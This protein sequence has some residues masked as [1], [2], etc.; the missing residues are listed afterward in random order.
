M[1]KREVAESSC[2]G[3]A[4]RRTR[5][6]FLRSKSAKNVRGKT[7]VAEVISLLENSDEEGCVNVKN[8]GPQPGVNVENAD[9]KPG[10]NGENTNPKP[11]QSLIWFICKIE[12]R[13]S[14]IEPI[15]DGLE[16]FMEE[17]SQSANEEF[18]ALRKS[19][20]NL[21]QHIDSSPSSAAPDN[22]D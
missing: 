19:I 5:P 1:S 8:A 10:V 22:S 7:E 4:P 13:V 18:S 16:K 2:A 21:N 3:S 6:Y 12:E 15:L 20:V 11:R 17:F 14:Q 9:P